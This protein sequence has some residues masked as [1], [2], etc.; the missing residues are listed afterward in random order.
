MILSQLLS[1][2]TEDQNKNEH[3]DWISL[4]VLVVEEN[5]HAT[6]LIHMQEATI[7]IDES[8]CTPI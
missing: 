2:E 6:I 3:M 5:I 7:N 1:P 4:D 8:E